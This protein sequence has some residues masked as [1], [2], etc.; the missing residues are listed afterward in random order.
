MASEAALELRFPF[1]RG[2]ELRLRFV[3]VVGPHESQFQLKWA[4]LS[5]FFLLCGAIC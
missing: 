3:W 5:W 1:V 4:R 2:L